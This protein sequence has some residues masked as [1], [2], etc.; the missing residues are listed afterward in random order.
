[1]LVASDSDGYFVNFRISESNLEFDNLGVIGITESESLSLFTKTSDYNKDVFLID[2]N[3]M[4]FL[5][6]KDAYYSRLYTQRTSDENREYSIGK[7]DGREIA[8]YNDE[9][10]SAILYSSVTSEGKRAWKY[11]QLS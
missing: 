1:M 8:A 3:R 10:E 11:K 5:P 2:G 4:P 9:D 6:N 7:Y